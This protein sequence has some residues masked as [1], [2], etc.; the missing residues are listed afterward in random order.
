MGGMIKTLCYKEK[1][2]DGLHKIKGFRHAR[3]TKYIKN[4]PQSQERNYRSG[5]ALIMEF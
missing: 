1:S 5:R 3:E 2:V 4:T